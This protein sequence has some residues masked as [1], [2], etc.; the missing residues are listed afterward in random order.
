MKY[1]ERKLKGQRML[2][3]ARAPDVRAQWGQVS[4]GRGLPGCEGCW[5]TLPPQA[6]G[7]SWLREEGPVSWGSFLTHPLPFV[8]A[9]Q[10][11]GEHFPVFV[12][13]YGIGVA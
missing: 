3:P 11:P 6:P 8:P 4:E 13:G 12:L 7:E 2:L 9:A 10:R 1:L 5:G